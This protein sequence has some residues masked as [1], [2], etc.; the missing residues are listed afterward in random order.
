MKLRH[1]QSF[2][3]FM[4][5]CA[6]GAKG[7]ETLYNSTDNTYCIVGKALSR[8]GV[9]QEKLDGENLP[10]HLAVKNHKKLW[11]FSKITSLWDEGKSKECLTYIRKRYKGRTV[12][13]FINMLTRAGILE[14]EVTNIN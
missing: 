1:N 3:R 12:G 8:V 10:E 2:Y 9:P 7:H 14:N 11:G 4:V 13:D 6:R 5:S